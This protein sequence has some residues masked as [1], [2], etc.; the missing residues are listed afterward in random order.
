MIRLVAACL[1]LAVAAPLARAQS[2]ADR[3]RADKLNDEGKALI[4]QVN[5]EAA[6]EKFRA[7]IA[8]SAD[9]RYYFNL[10][11]TLDRQG[12]LREAK[13]A[14]EAVAAGG[15]DARLVEKARNRLVEI[16]RAIRAGQDG[17]ASGAGASETLSDGEQVRPGQVSTVSPSVPGA[18]PSQVGPRPAQPRP[19]QPAPA[20][21]PA[22]AHPDG[23]PAPPA[24][25]PGATFTALLGFGFAQLGI[26]P[27]DSGVSN[28]GTSAL[29]IGGGVILWRGSLGIEISGLLARRGTETSFVDP[30]TFLVN[31]AEILYTYLDVDAAAR[32]EFSSRRF[33]PYA[34][35]GAYLGINLGTD[36]KV[37]GMDFEVTEVA[38]TDF[39]LLL[40]GGCAFG[41]F[42]RAFSIEFRYAHG[43][44]DVDDS[45]IF[46]VT[47]QMGLL[48]GGYQF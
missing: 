5:F 9:P 13:A 30:D 14:C 43:L 28:D 35:G 7:A 4:Q 42:H 6:A 34:L 39:G 27:Q 2:A 31:T 19:T 36:G 16:D 44:A 10:C 26:E 45:D 40:G 41:G 21:P 1:A 20:R 8:I 3:A 17:R 29:G 33:R 38:A 32:Y 47:H 48:L 37:N 22:P 46:K 12:K 25:R 23:P 24:E 11:Y 18:R 15:S